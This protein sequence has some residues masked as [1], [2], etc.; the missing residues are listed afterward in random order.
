LQFLSGSIFLDISSFFFV[1]MTWMIH[2][3]HLPAKAD[4]NHG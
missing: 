2:L 3:S 1:F 4:A